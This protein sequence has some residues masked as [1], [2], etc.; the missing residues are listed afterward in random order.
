ML[1]DQE[2]QGNK[3][4]VMDQNNTAE[5]SESIVR[6]AG[7]RPWNMRV[8]MLTQ[9]YRSPS[10]RSA[11]SSRTSSAQT[12]RL[13]P[14]QPRASARQAPRTASLPPRTAVGRMGA[15]RS[16]YPGTMWTGPHPA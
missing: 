15:Y 11:P 8:L 4:P 6:L 10:P 2:E 1:A 14:L 3:R 12:R 5:E 13:Q 9:P 16:T 7:M